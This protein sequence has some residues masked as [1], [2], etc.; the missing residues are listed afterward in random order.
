MRIFALMI[1]LLSSAAS[2]ATSFEQIG[3]YD[4]IVPVNVNEK[5]YVGRY[6]EDPHVHCRFSLGFQ[7]EEGQS[8]NLLEKEFLGTD[9]AGDYLADRGPWFE[10]NFEEGYIALNVQGFT[11][12]DDPAPQE[13]DSFYNEVI[14]CMLLLLLN[15]LMKT[16]WV[17]NSA[18]RKVLLIETGSF[19]ENRRKLK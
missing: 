1:C 18:N 9:E 4:L 12:I 8:F 5:C 17:G 19:F 14:D 3:T 6:G 7:A 10:I 13:L 16:I 2:S 15:S 11:W